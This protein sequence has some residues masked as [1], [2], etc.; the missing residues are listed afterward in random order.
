MATTVAPRRALPTT[1]TSARRVARARSREDLGRGRSCVVLHRGVRSTCAPDTSAASSGW[2]RRSRSGISLARPRRTS[3]ACCATTARRRSTT[4]CCTSGWAA[5]GDIGDGNP[6]A[7][8]ELFGLLTIPAGMWVAWSLFGRRAG[9]FAAVLFAF[10]PFIT[11]YGQE[12][13]MYTLM[14]LLGL[15]A[16]GAFIHALRLPPAPLPDPVRDLQ[17]LML[18]THAWGIFF[19][20]G[21]VARARSRCGASER[22]AG[23]AAGRALRLRRR[24][25]AVPARGFRRCI[26]QATNTGCAVG[27]RAATSARRSR[28]R[29]T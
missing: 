4:C 15:L 18:Y 21:A 12:T 28:S 25:G 2:T 27:H 14:A 6:R 13:R 16:T 1:S 9:L 7:V 23:P 8:A 24:R 3:P 17:A 20:V 19:G 26:Y 5:F 11:A 29:A 10:N 22:S